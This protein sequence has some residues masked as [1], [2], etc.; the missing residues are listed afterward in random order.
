MSGTNAHVILQEAGEP[1][2]AASDGPGDAADDG[3]ADG[4]EQPPLLRPGT[5]P[6]VVSGRTPAG[7]AAQA[8]RLAG[9]VA[10]RPGL[11]PDDVAWSLAATRSAH[12]QRAVVIG[13]DWDEL[14]AG[15]AAVAAGRPGPGVITGAAPAAPAARAPRV[16]FVFPGQGGQWAGMGRELA[17]AS[18]AF[19]ARLAE[20]AR[21]LA[22]F[23]GWDL[24]EVLARDEL[25]DRA[26]VV[27]PAL[28]AVMVSLA[29]AWQAAGVV[30]D[31]VVGHSQGEIA[32]A[33]V[34][35]ICPWRTA[36]GSWRCA[37]RR[38]WRCQAGAGWC[39]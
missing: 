23:T 28:W 3:A 22:P 39:R 12:E 13:A 24:D 18:P 34:A 16:V 32:A 26:D 9:W 29:A 27:Q 17:A 2:A 36:P 30:P 20:C 1:E 6:W 7:L 37:A 21:A 8:G 31:A 14:T 38:C 10:A 15:L 4:T 19:A 5:V 25:P 11:D 35:G 33:V